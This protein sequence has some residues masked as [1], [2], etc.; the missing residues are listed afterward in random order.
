MVHVFSHIIQVVV[1]ASGTDALLGVGGTP[2][3]GHG[4]GRVDGVEEDGLELVRQRTR[5]A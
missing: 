3:L 4:V 2:Q 5:A 1:F